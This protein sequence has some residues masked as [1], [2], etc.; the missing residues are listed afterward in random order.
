MEELAIAEEAARQKVC[1]EEN[2]AVEEAARKEKDA[3]E[4]AAA[5]EGC[6]MAIT[7]EVLGKSTS[8]EDV[9]SDPENDWALPAAEEH[10]IHPDH[11]GVAYNEKCAA[12]GEKTTITAGVLGQSTSTEDV[13]S[14][15]E[16]DWVLIDASSVDRPSAESG[17]Q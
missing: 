11:G 5:E 9:D 14:E 1:A 6:C 15:P 4:K 8:T 12:A 13:D 16:N 2:A 17:Q 10:R 3:E 7:E